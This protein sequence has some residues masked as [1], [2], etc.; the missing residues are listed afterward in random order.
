MKQEPINFVQERKRRRPEEQTPTLEA[1]RQEP[2]EERLPSRSQPEPAP[3]RAPEPKNGPRCSCCECPLEKVRV[4]LDLGGGRLLCN[5]CIKIC[6][7]I[8][9]EEGITTDTEPEK[10]S[11][12][13][14]YSNRTRYYCTFCGREYA[15]VGR[16]I[17]MLHGIY[18]CNKCVGICNTGISQEAASTRPTDQQNGETMV[19]AETAKGGDH[20]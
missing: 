18:I 1:S 6:N 14:S 9:S 20:A 16:L 5:G 12:A 11:I 3:K 10:T 15:Q 19:S 2:L 13:S 7:D 4:L 17:S 8:L